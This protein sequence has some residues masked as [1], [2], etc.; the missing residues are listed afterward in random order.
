[1]LIKS[2]NLLSTL[3]SSTF[4]PSRSSR[5]IRSFVYYGKGGQKLEEKIQAWTE[6][7]P[8]QI[9]FAS[10]LTK[11]DPTLSKFSFTLHDF[12]PTL[13]WISLSSIQ[14]LKKQSELDYD[15]TLGLQAQKFIFSY[16]VWECEF[17][18]LLTE[19]DVIVKFGLFFSFYILLP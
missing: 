13:I 15:V 17:L 7:F 11:I 19:S 12:P 10:N 16:S 18:S 14:K 4:A 3:F 2:T 6:F 8:T 1:M 9:E 5:S